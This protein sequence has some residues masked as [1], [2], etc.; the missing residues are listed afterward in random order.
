M[1]LQKQILIFLAQA[2]PTKNKHLAPCRV[3]HSKHPSFIALILFYT[4]RQKQATL[5]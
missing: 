5:S 2:V 4:H 3:I 1:I